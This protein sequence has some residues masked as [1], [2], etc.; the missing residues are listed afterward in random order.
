MV[1]HVTNILYI[2]FVSFGDVLISSSIIRKLK[3]KH[4]NSRIDY[5]TTSACSPLLAGNP[6]ISQIF[7]ERNPPKNLERYDIV[8]RP[9]RCLQ[10]TAWWHRS[11]KHSTD[12][13]AEVCGVDLKGDYRLFFYNIQETPL[14]VPRYILIQCKTNDPAKDY[15]RFPELV[16]LINRTIKIPV[17]QVGGGNDPVIPRT[18]GFVKNEAW[19]KVA[20]LIQNALQTVCLDSCCQHLC[21]SLNA[22]CIALYGAKEARF[23]RSGVGVLDGA[24]L[25]HQ[26]FLNP[27]DRNGCPTWCNL[28]VCQNLKGKCI[29]NILPEEIVSKINETILQIK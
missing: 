14:P 4:T 19:P 15:D 9:Y 23:V 20:Y 18:I 13:L 25:P 11:G 3:E 28:G 10:E 1:H 5:Y 8:L 26:Y 17:V 29:N 24:T 7:T 2:Q 27:P 21:S 16:D 22:P 6:D 12:L